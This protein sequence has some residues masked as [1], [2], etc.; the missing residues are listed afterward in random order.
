[1]LFPPST[2]TTKR[3]FLATVV[4]RYCGIG[5]ILRGVVRNFIDQIAISAVFTRNW[6]K[7]QD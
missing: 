7:L 1:M 4:I 2:K 3:P 5:N 6:E